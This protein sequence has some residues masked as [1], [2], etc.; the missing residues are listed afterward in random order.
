MTLARCVMQTFRVYSVGRRPQCLRRGRGLTQYICPVTMC[1]HTF[2]I[3]LQQEFT[4]NASDKTQS[5]IAQTLR[6]F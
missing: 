6:S 4:R 3:S 5:S 1:W 2:K